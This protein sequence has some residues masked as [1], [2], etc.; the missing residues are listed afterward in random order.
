[1]AVSTE[2]ASSLDVKCTANQPQM[3]VTFPSSNFDVW[4]KQ[5]LLS[6]KGG[7]DG[8]RWKK[9]GKNHIPISSLIDQYILTCRTEGK[10]FSTLRGYKEKLRRFLGWE[11]TAKLGNF[12][13]EMVRDYISHLQSAR[14]YEGHPVNPT[15]DRLLSQ[16]AVRNH[17]MVLRSFSSWLYRELYTTDHL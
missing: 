10:T 16:A 13:V 12:T 11:E 3:R 7:S 14:K 17:V 6:K 8:K 1:M 15:Q 4:R 2:M 5:C 9:M